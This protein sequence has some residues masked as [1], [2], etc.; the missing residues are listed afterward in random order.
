[1]N[2]NLGWVRSSFLPEV[3]VTMVT[4]TYLYGHEFVAVRS[5][6]V[7][8]GVYG[9]VVECVCDGGVSLSPALPGVVEA[10]LVL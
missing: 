8:T 1:M 2:M 6:P 5:A 7:Y 4:M 9:E 10:A 3:T